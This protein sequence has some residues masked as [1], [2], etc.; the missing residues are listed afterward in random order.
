MQTDEKSIIRGLVEGT[1][2]AYRYVFKV[3]YGP[4]CILAESILLQVLFMYES[5]DCFFYPQF[6]IFQKTRYYIKKSYQFIAF[7]RI[8]CNFAPPI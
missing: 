8:I 4:M 6:K 5:F 2:D 3:Y 7:L 1:E